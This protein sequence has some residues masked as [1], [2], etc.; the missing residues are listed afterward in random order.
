MQYPHLRL[1]GPPE[2]HNGRGVVRL[3]T[4]KHL[5][6]LVILALEG[7]ARGVLRAR[8]IDLLWPDVSGEAGRHSLSQGLT[9]IRRALG[10]AAVARG[11]ERIRLS[12]S[13]TTDLDVLDGPGLALD[14][15]LL[16]LETCAG[17]AFA[18]WVDA[19]RERCLKEARVALATALSAARDS[20]EVGAVR[21]R[22]ALLYLVD[23]LSDRAALAL[24]EGM[25]LDGDRVAAIQF[26][27]QHGARTRREVGCE[28]GP[29]IRRRLR[30]IER[31][32]EDEPARPSW[33]IST[34][35]AADLLIGRDAELARLEALWSCTERAGVVTCLVT[36]P[37]GI[38]KSTLVRRFAES[39]AAR[40]WPTY[41]TACQ[42]IGRAIPFAAVSELIYLLARD[43]AI[44]GAD[45]RWLSEISRV[46]PGLRARYPGIPDPPETP[47]ES[48]KIRVAESLD[49]IL[50]V[51]ADGDRLLLVLDDIQHL[52]SSSR[53]ILHVLLRRLEATR[54]ML[55]GTLRSKHERGLEFGE[56]TAPDLSWRHVVSLGALQ[57]DVAMALIAA[58]GSGRRVIDASVRNII[59]KLADGNPYLLEMLLADWERDGERSLVGAEL[60]GGGRAI[61]WNPPETMRRAFARQYEGLSDTAKHVLAVL[62]VAGK[63]LTTEEI[64]QV[65]GQFSQGIHPSLFELLERRIAQVDNLRFAFRNEMQRAFVYYVLTGEETRK[66]CHERLAHVIATT[67]KNQDFQR[68]LE[69]SHHLFRADLVQ[70]A[71]SESLDGAELAVTHGAPLEAER[72]ITKMRGYLN[73][74]LK[75]KLLLVNTRALLALGKHQEARRELEPLASGSLSPSE[76]ATRCVLRADALHQGG[77]AGDIEM[78]EAVAVAL[79]A[80]DRAQV[81]RLMVKAL[82]ITAE[83]ATEAG[84]LETMGR[85]Q[86]RVWAL[87]RTSK[88]HETRAMAQVTLGYCLLVS[89]EHSA[90]ITHLESARTFMHEDGRETDLRGVVNGLGIAYN[91]LGAFREAEECFQEA[92]R[93]AHGQG[94][95]NAASLSW[96]NLALLYDDLGWFNRSADA[97]R[98]ALRFCEQSP[99]PRRQVKILANAAGLAISLGNYKEAEKLLRQAHLQ[100]H[101]SKKR[102]LLIDVLLEYADLSLA[103]GDTETAWSHVEQILGLTGGKTPV[104]GAAH[105]FQRLWLQYLW[106]TQG[107]RA[108]QRQLAMVKSAGLASRLAVRLELRAFVDWTHQQ[109]RSSADS[110]AMSEILNR[111][112][113]GVVA[114]LLALKICPSKLQKNSCESSSARA[115]ARAF[116]DRR[117]AT[118]PADVFVS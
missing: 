57:A 53:D 105:Q 10:G 108:L 34:A 104:H 40:G 11:R 23:P 71:L 58:R 82:Q 92:V 96:D 16:G 47:P 111:Q 63:A 25:L 26:L 5:A 3:R 46:T 17:P 102:T 2:L 8:L 100:A 76:E 79:R 103:L 107:H 86:K 33:G 97:Y 56:E 88:L 114:R 64:E 73:G 32:L 109:T 54:V 35:A 42:E 115:V 51:L 52:D 72:L 90:A 112:L 75:P 37:A 67:K 117:R 48:V 94:S 45:P 15:P 84:D 29:E 89:G 7:R 14:Q 59:I 99:T 30:R 27:R 38:G 80:A 101:E 6:L 55:L 95:A 118:L 4:R 49:R 78:R 87:H 28:A 1:F 83:V 43:P 19:A 68:T 62:A 31:N 91:N 77:L 22:A 65:L 41:V 85:V 61:E 21:E 60:E 13:L 44:S 106:S 93:L 116:P 18:H 50:A 9:V 113:F 39:I 81:E 66:F 12:L 110:A 74:E 69:L 24:A 98:T 20:G 36:G 70:R